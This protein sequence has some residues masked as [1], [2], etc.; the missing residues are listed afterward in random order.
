[1]GESQGW[2]GQAAW[3]MR[4]RQTRMRSLVCFFQRGLLGSL[5]EFPG[6]GQPS[7]RILS[8]ARDLDRR[9]AGE[10]PTEGPREGAE[11]C[12]TSQ[13]WSLV[14]NFPLILS[15]RFN[16][17]SLLHLRMGLICLRPLDLPIGQED[18]RG[19]DLRAEGCAKALGTGL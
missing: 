8:W 10:E 12:P 11:L 17:R 7:V 3:V 15:P 6:A 1:M 18:R 19:E 4:P 16:P 5:E 14:P 13:P 2:K 9:V